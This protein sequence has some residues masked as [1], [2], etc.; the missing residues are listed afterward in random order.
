MHNNYKI[1]NYVR[2][3]G[4]H[5]NLNTYCIIRIRQKS[6]LLVTFLHMSVF[7][8]QGDREGVGSK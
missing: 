8:S 7:V 4:F 3:L 2:E 1:H 6:E 5:N